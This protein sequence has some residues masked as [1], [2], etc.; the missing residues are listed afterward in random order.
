METKHI[1]YKNFNNKNKQLNKKKLNNFIKFKNL[2]EKYPLLKSLTNNY[3]YSF[4]K[5]NL[6]NFKKYDEY[7]LIGMGG[8]ILGAQAIYD[9]LNHKIKKKFFFYNN[10]QNIRIT[11]SNKK[12]LNIIISKSGNTLETLSN[13]NLILSK[14]KRNK[15]L[16]INE[17]KK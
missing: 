3:N 9:F 16:I 15:N 7:N 2:I 13:L 12:R 11:K 6:L 17:K 4:Q 8:S 5:K 14:Q 1:I 10:L